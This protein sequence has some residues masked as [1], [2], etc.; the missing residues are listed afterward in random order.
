MSE[1]CCKGHQGTANYTRRLL[2]KE[3][4]KKGLVS[5]RCE[6][7]RQIKADNSLLRKLQKEVKAYTKAAADNVPAIATKLE[8]FFKSLVIY[9]FQIHLKKRQ[10][11]AAEK[12]LGELKELMTLYEDYT[13][14]IST[15]AEERK[16]YNGMLNNLKPYQQVKF[17]KYTS[18]VTL[19]TEEIEDFKY[20]R[21]SAISRYGMPEGTRKSDIEK[22]IKDAEGIVSKLDKQIPDIKKSKDET[23]DKYKGEIHDI[24]SD[25]FVQISEE[26]TKIHDDHVNE[27]R[28]TLSNCLKTSADKE[29]F[30]KATEEVN[31]ELAD[32]EPSVMP[33]VEREKKSLLAD[34][35]VDKEIIAR[36]PRKITE[37]EKDKGMSL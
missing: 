17:V 4:R 33:K 27:A 29:L 20:D 12:R 14:K 10:K 6:I 34:L 30:D 21:A 36:T 32:I 16:E 11:K 19:L 7:N 3:H 9:S 8:K 13:S 31:A 1:P 25:M 35:R 18:H 37:K 15:R 28:H 24:S 26:R 23:L 5:D 22:A 2:C